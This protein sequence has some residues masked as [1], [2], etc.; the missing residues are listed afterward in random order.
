MPFE[1]PEVA[2]STWVVDLDLGKASLEELEKQVAR[3]YSFSVVA[4]LVS[5]GVVRIIVVGR[6][7]VFQFAVEMAATAGSFAEVEPTGSSVEV[8][9][10][11]EKLGQIVPPFFVIMASV[12]AFSFDPPLDFSGSMRLHTDR[13]VVA[14]GILGLDLGYID[15]TYL[16]DL[17]FYFNKIR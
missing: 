5:V 1:L 16:T 12:L 17:L 10:A 8:A 3:K 2:Q 11:W 15:R 4:E 14:V 7:V 13:L 6:S 9:V